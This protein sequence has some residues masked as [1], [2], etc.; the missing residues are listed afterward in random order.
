MS[1]LRKLAA[2][3]ALKDH[4]RWGRFALESVEITANR[5]LLWL[6]GEERHDDSRPI[7]V[8]LVQLGEGHS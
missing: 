1:D 6:Q 3:M 8:E 5:Y 4:E 7:T 2:E